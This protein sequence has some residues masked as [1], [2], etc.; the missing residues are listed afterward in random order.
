MKTKT[1]RRIMICLLVAALLAAVG[2]S[3]Y[4]AA[5]NYAGSKAVNMIITNQIN[6]MLDS[7]EVTLSDLEE[8]IAEPAKTE[9]ENDNTNEEVKTDTSVQKAP[10]PTES[11]KTRTEVVKQ[12]SE[13]VEKG[14]SRADK[15]AMAK[16]IGS[17][18]SAADVRY[19]TGLVAGGLTAE[20]ISA[21]ARLAYSRFSAEEITQVKTYWHRYKNSIKRAK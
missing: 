1:K 13:K 6:D 16:L 20:E 21:A 12:A 14:I 8:I 9:E 4:R 3:A 17:R 19:L 10:N 7:G 11:P 15:E 2:Y 18:L 5:L